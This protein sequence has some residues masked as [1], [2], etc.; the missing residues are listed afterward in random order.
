MVPNPFLTVARWLTPLVALV[1]ALPLLDTTAAPAPPLAASGSDA[2]PAASHPGQVTTDPAAQNEP[3]VAINPLD[4]DQILVTWNDF[5]RG[6]GRT[7]TGVGSSLDAGQT[8]N[9]RLV[10]PNPETPGQPPA[11]FCTPADSQASGGDP[12]AAFNGGG[13]GLIGQFVRCDWTHWSIMVLPTFDGGTTFDPPVYPVRTGDNMPT[14]LA[15]KPWLRGDPTSSWTY[16]C[17][18]NQSVIDFRGAEIRSVTNIYFTATQDPQGREWTTPRPISASP[19]GHEWPL[20]ADPPI[21]QVPMLCDIGIGPDHTVYVTYMDR[22]GQNHDQYSI[23]LVQSLDH[24]LTFTPPRTIALVEGSSLPEAEP[25]QPNMGRIAVSPI[26]GAIYVVWWEGDGDIVLIRSTDHG[27]AWSPKIRVNNDAGVAR[28]TLPSVGVYPDGRVAVGFYD[29]RD[30]PANRL[31]RYYVAESADGGQTFPLQAAAGP[32]AIDAY[33]SKSP[34]SFL[35]FIGD[36]TDLIIGPDGVLHCAWT[37][38]TTDN[39]DIFVGPSAP[40]GG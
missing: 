14:G 34:V 1:V 30:D 21:D 23:R 12:V 2:S 5:R 9:S 26:D 24:G 27:V 33:D 36:Y 10:T 3:A 6:P 19:L 40:A 29:R 20:P 38:V 37:A 7:W 35:N 31:M 15:D 11:E 39:Q 32:A 18:T 17:W 16:L 13:L 4:P 28:Q 22:W 25:R 8:W